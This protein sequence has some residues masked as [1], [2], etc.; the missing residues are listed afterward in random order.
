M[1][2]SRFRRVVVAASAATLSLGLISTGVVTSATGAATSGPGVS[3]TQI[4]IGATVPLSGIA[5]SYAEVS[6]TAAAVFK[7][8]NSKGGVNGRKINYIRK[9]DCYDIAN[10]DATCTAGSKS[11]SLTAVQTTA[12]LGTPGGILG[13]VGSLGTTAQDS[14]QKSLNLAKVPQLFVSSGA[15]DWNQPTKYPYTFGFQ[16]SYKVEGKIFA[17]YIKANFK[18]AK[19]AFI[20]Q[21]DFGPAGLAGLK[22]G[23]VNPVNSSATQFYS[24]ADV[25]LGTA[26]IQKDVLAVRTS[27][28]TVVV[29]DSIPAFTQA[30]LHYAVSDSL[31]NVHWVISSVGSDPVAVNDKLEVGAITLDFFPSTNAPTNKWNIWLRKVLTADHTDFP[32]FNSATH[33]DGNEQYGAAYAVAFL[34][35]LKTL[36]ANVSRTG[37]QK[38]M[39]TAAM[40]TQAVVPLKYSSANHQGLLGGVIAVVAPNGTSVP[41]TVNEPSTTTYLSTDANSSAVTTSH[42]VTSAIPSWLS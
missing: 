3:P 38:A 2:L 6:A 40:T 19:V 32:G 22:A 36:G 7:Y 8:V 12:L 20:G 15:S 28:A 5:K 9:D 27:G 30:I 23:G 42:V 18:N 39:T 25:F 17:K 14:V 21:S 10:F 37:I 35:A 11:S 1:S 41:W 29:L 16:T 33:L 31:S 24:S 13:T 26:D 4:T 34:E